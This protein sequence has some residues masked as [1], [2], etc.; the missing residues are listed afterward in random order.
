MQLVTHLSSLEQQVV[1]M[2]VIVPKG[3]LEFVEDPD[4][5]SMQN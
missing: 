5:F 4:Y 2:V 1:L 3:E